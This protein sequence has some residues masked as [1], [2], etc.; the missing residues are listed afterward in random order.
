MDCILIERVVGILDDH[1]LNGQINVDMAY[2]AIDKQ[3][4]L[5]VAD[6]TNKL[7]DM[8]YED[9]TIP[10]KTRIEVCRNMA[11]QF[12][13]VFDTNN[14][15]P[16]LSPE[17]N[18]VVLHNEY[19]FISNKQ[20]KHKIIYNNYKIYSKYDHVSHWSSEFRNIP[21][22]NRHIRIESSLSMIILSMRELLKLPYLFG[23]DLKKEISDIMTNIDDYFKNIEFNKKN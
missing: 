19:T 4:L 3:C 13:N 6:G 7:I 18:N 8:L 5:Y 10:L 17:F 12:P 20:K 23:V 14:N 21:L 11:N 9:E 1:I 22:K 15:K 2:I 16:K